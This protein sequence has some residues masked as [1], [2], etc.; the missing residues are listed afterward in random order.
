MVTCVV[1]LRRAYDGSLDAEALH[2][3]HGQFGAEQEV[4]CKD[5][6]G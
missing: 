5:K 4:P 1:A 2:L 3:Q 6:S